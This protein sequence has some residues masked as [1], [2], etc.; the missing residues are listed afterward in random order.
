M[1]FRLSFHNFTL[2]FKV[3]WSKKI[4]PHYNPVFYS[5]LYDKIYSGNMTVP[6]DTSVQYKIVH[7]TNLFAKVFNLEVLSRFLSDTSAKIELIHLERIFEMLRRLIK[8]CDDI[9]FLFHVQWP[10]SLLTIFWDRD[11]KTACMNLFSLSSPTLALTL[12]WRMILTLTSLTLTETE[13]IVCVFDKDVI[14]NLLDFPNST[15]GPCVGFFIPKGAI[16][17]MCLC[18]T[19]MWYKTYL[20]PLVP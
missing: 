5:M 13:V 1:K 19:T 16:V 18:L 11:W 14:Q 20:T 2:S 7:G 10:L 15:R 6:Q 17:F 9:S 4:F 8:S 12:S 3:N